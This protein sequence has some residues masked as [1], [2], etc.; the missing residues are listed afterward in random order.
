[1]GY[2]VNYFQLFLLIM[3]RINAMIVIAPLYSSDVI[4]Y[5]L[6]AIFTFFVSLILF[7][8]VAAK[9]FSIPGNMGEYALLIFG[10]AAIGLYLGFLVSVIFA[11]FQLSGQYFA[12][13]I[14]FGINEVLDPLGQI[15]VPLVGQFKNL[16][17]LLVFLAINGHH[18]M[19][20]AISRSFE[21]A[22]LISFHREAAGGLLKYLAYTFSGM[23]VVALKISL[24]V[25][26]TVFL[27]TVTLGVLAKAAPQMNIMMLGFPFKIV[28]SFIVLLL[29][30][31][32]VIRIMQVSLERTFSFLSNV[33]IHWPK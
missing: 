31:P 4:P 30:A 18:M 21:L 26:G 3:V 17:G 29:S 27:V 23:F 15:S 19:L 13:Q 6:K 2:F 12:V 9:G 20:A 11:A 24:P 5:R 33:L 28:V 14:G 10:N 8:L 16:M 32:L 25:V 7:P 22:P 1:M